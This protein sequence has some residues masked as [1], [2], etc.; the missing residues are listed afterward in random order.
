[1][2]KLKYKLAILGAVTAVA[3]PVVT[4]IVLCTKDKKETQTVTLPPGVTNVTGAK[5]NYLIDALKTAGI[6]VHDEAIGD[7]HFND[8][9]RYQQDGTWNTAFAAIHFMI[10]EDISFIDTASHDAPEGFI[11]LEKGHGITIAA[12]GPKGRE[13]D[14]IKIIYRDDDGHDVSIASEHAQEILAKLFGIVHPE[15]WT[16]GGDGQH[17]I[18]AADDMIITHSWSEDTNVNLAA[19][20]SHMPT[21]LTDKQIRKVVAAINEMP[22]ADVNKLTTIDLLVSK[23]DLTDPTINLTHKFSATVA[24][25]DA[26]NF[27]KVKQAFAAVNGSVVDPIE[28]EASNLPQYAL[29]DIVDAIEIKDFASSRTTA[30]LL[31]VLSGAKT[32]MNATELGITLPGFLKDN[33]ALAVTFESKAAWDGR[34]VM[35]LIMHLKLTGEDGTVVSREVPGIRLTRPMN[36][37][38]VMMDNWKIP[39]NMDSRFTR[40]QLEHLIKGSPNFYSYEFDSPKEHFLVRHWRLGLKPLENY[41]DAPAG[42]LQYPDY[43]C[44]YVPK[45]TTG[46]TDGWDASGDLHM[47]FTIEARRTTETVAPKI[48]KDIVIHPATAIDGEEIW[49]NEDVQKM[50][51][52]KGSLFNIDEAQHWFRRQHLATDFYSPGDAPLDKSKLDQTD[53][54]HLSAKR[55]NSF[56][57]VRDNE[58]YKPGEAFLA[59]KGL[60]MIYAIPQITLDYPNLKWPLP[61]RATIVSDEGTEVT[62]ATKD[63]LFKFDGKYSHWFDEDDDDHHIV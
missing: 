26:G 37:T 17:S 6:Q 63:F 35:D 43:L 51:I 28:D 31:A 55:L 39:T 25:G 36:V 18:L 19:H 49:K 4:V 11:T 50:L 20:V 58:W 62:C 24:A 10:N 21:T 16:E 56:L 52:R 22:T 7:I 30:D 48:V 53:Y 57:M 15:W 54:N 34:S 41:P 3:A 23:I 5:K 2:T 27:T 9:F 33:T 32:G 1:M 12:T 8:N 14:E 45:R 38:Q 61:I 29:T 59:T 47:T 13:M 44:K 42:T 60:K 46:F 40:R